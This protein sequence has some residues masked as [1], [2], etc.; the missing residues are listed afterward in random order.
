M[1]PN[2]RIDSPYY[3]LV[4]VGDDSSETDGRPLEDGVDTPGAGVLALRGA[5]LGPRGARRTIDMTV[6]RTR[7]GVR[8]FPGAKFDEW[9]CRLSQLRRANQGRPRPLSALL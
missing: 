3:V 4:M 1:L 5:A 9:I 2:N 8:V 6:G 7:A